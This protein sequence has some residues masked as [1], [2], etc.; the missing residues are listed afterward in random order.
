M[1]ERKRREFALPSGCFAVGGSPLFVFSDPALCHA[2]CLLA[3]WFEA[4]SNQGTCCAC[5]LPEM[6]TSSRHVL[7][8]ATQV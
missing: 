8:V 6:M 2:A 7:P 4:K 5:R 3:R 1:S